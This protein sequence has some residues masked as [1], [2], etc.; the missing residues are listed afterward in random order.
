MAVSYGVYETFHVVFKAKFTSP[1]RYFQD[2][3][4]QSKWLQE[5]YH[6]NLLDR[7]PIGHEPKEYQESN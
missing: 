1:E 6:G 5:I 4:A 2:Q 3:T 7:D